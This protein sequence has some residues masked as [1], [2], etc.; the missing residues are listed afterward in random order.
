[1]ALPT[2][3]LAAHDIVNFVL[4]HGNAEQS[5]AA[6]EVGARLAGLTLRTLSAY[7][8]NP[9]ASWSLTEV[10]AALALVDAYVDTIEEYD[11]LVEAAAGMVLQ[12]VQV[13]LAAEDAAADAAGL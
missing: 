3:L 8:P 2:D 12:P 1:M 5:D 11:G 13:L 10:A 6:A 7:Q 9:D 4:E